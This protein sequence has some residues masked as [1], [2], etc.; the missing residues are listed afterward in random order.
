[1]KVTLN[2]LINLRN[3]LAKNL[4]GNN[5]YAYE[6]DFFRA[7]TNVPVDIA[8]R[9]L[10]EFRLKKITEQNDI[11]EA[12]DTLS[13]IKILI[14]DANHANGVDNILAEISKTDQK[15]SSFPHNTDASSPNDYEDFKVAM[16]VTSSSPYGN[17]KLFHYLTKEERESHKNL[18]KE[19]VKTRRALVEQRNVINHKTLVELPEDVVA[20]LKK[21]DLV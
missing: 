16:S 11:F 7:P 13:A 4:S 12:I 5:K 21:I 3:D 19:L 17:E 6:E 18:K 2:K 8:E 9:K 10:E 15:I 20:V 14:S 1:M